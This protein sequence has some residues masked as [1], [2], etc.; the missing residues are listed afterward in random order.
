[1]VEAEFEHGSIMPCY[2]CGGWWWWCNC[3][4][5]VFL[6][7]FR[8]ISACWALPTWALFLTMSIPLWPPCTHPLMATSSQQDNAPCHKAWII[9]NWFLEHDNE[10]TVLKWPPQSPDLN[11]IEHLCDVVE[12]ELSLCPG[13]ASH[14]SPS[15]RWYPINMDQ[16]F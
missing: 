4:G 1:M 12:R 3:V 13:C 5:D 6:A 11:P 8:P 10:F 9:S 15:T 2:H 7:Q 14:K 16:Q